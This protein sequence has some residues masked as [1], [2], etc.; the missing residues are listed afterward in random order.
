M[1]CHY[2]GTIVPSMNGSIIYN[3]I[4]NLLLNGNLDMSYADMKEMFFHGLG[5]NYNNIDVEITWRSQISKYQYYLVPIVRDD[6]F[7]I[8][9]DFFIQS[10][11]NIIVL[12]VIS[13]IKSL[14]V[15][16]KIIY[17]RMIC[18]KGLMIL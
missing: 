2:S 7:K 12:Y 1:L 14:Y 15:R 10:G 16:V 3:D 8:T 9:I 11:L 18:Y 5:W 13:R 6:N 4:N 17:S